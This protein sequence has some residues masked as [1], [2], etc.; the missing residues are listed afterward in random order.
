MEPSQ[1]DK[2]ELAVFRLGL[3]PQNWAWDRAVEMLLAGRHPF[4]VRQCLLGVTLDTKMENDCS[5]T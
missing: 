5:A 2:A 4:D 1:Y 3:T